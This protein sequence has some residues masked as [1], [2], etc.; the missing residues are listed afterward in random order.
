MSED[1]NRGW[2]ADT[3]GERHGFEGDWRD[4]W[5]N[6]DF[7]DLMA[8]RWRLDA[9]TCALDVGCGVGHWGQLLAPRCAP[10][11]E[12][13]GLDHEGGFRIPAEERAARRELTFTFHEATGDAL[14]FADASFDLVT[15]QTVLM[16]VP[17][18]V[19]VLAEMR[20][21]VRPGGLVVASEP[22]NLANALVESLAAPRLPFE[23]T[24][25]LLR[26]QES[27][28]R[29]KI[30]LGRGDNSVG[31]RLPARFAEAGL[32]ELAGVSNDRCPALVPPYVD[33]AQKRDI[34]QQ[35]RFLDEAASGWGAKE[36]VRELHRAAGGTPAAFDRGWASLAAHHERFREA[37]AAGTYAGARGITQYLVS[38]RRGPR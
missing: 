20:R 10:G 22:N 23:E 19:A 18:P 11:V 14:P 31:E 1:I 29:G 21:V 35:L 24:L 36:D 7:L 27:L 37:V 15:C 8:R 3:Y 12:L 5:W 9:V 33:A 6:A 17:D 13:H 30:A 25:E 16:H 2:S 34:A 28:H 26:F 4:D 38:G 32:V